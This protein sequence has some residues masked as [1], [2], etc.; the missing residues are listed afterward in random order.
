[1]NFY[2]IS[3]NVYNDGENYA[4]D[5]FDKKIAAVGWDKDKPKGKQFKGIANDDCIIV[6]QRKD[7]EWTYYYMGIVRKSIRWNL[8]KEIISN[9]FARK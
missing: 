9:S 2:V 5:M 3:P 6:A 8:V 7:W 1:M 4:K